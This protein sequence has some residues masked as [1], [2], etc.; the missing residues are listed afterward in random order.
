MSGGFGPEAE[1]D[2]RDDLDIL[3]DLQAGTEQY[4]RA[5]AEMGVI[6]RPGVGE[7]EIDFTARALK[8]GHLV[9]EE[10]KEPGKVF[11][12]PRERVTLWQLGTLILH[13]E[14]AK[15]TGPDPASGWRPV[16]D[17]GWSCAVYQPA[18]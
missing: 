9:T 1:P 18:G 6:I 3:S 15:I 10:L 11:V 2:G 14:R 4:I 5:L 12:Y 17:L 13:A 8:I 7:I 16:A